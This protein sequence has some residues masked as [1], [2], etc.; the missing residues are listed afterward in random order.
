MEKDQKGLLQRL[1]MA[2]KNLDAFATPVSLHVDGHATFKTC[3]GGWTTVFAII[4]IV[5][6]AI[7]EIVLANSNSNEFT[8]VEKQRY[9]I[10][11]STTYNLKDYNYA[12]GIA[13]SSSTV[14]PNLLFDISYFELKFIQYE[15]QR[16]AVNGNII[17]TSSQ[18]LDLVAWTNQFDPV[19]IS[20]P[21]T[22]QFMSSYYCPPI[23]DYSI[24]GHFLSEKFS[25]VNILIRKCT[26][27]TYW[28]TEAQINAVLPE[29]FISIANVEYFIETDDLSSGSKTRL[30]PTFGYELVDGIN[31]NYDIN[32]Q[33]NELK[34]SSIASPTNY[35]TTSPLQSKVLNHEG[36]KVLLL[37]NIMLDSKYISGQ[38]TFVRIILP[39]FSNVGGFIA[40]VLIMGSL[41][42]SFFSEFIYHMAMVSL[43][44]K[45]SDTQKGDRVAPFAEVLDR[46]KMVSHKYSSDSPDISM[47]RNIEGDHSYVG[48]KTFNILVYFFLEYSYSLLRRREQKR[49]IYER[50]KQ[51]SGYLIK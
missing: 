9:L 47:Q 27:Q 15:Y 38:T 7:F 3:I 16:D 43:I 24:G 18:E 13:S 42:V 35:I 5:I 8:A 49:Y 20:S 44:Y 28:K 22:S 11:D 2:T 10:E 14:D 25:K 1:V 17:S 40:L 36:S 50:R 31:Q 26:T 39:F 48:K 45:V 33:V 46:S 41:F 29:L 30:E 4:I 32:I 37:F 6:Y 12:F 21:L 34:D 19:L 51:K 23:N